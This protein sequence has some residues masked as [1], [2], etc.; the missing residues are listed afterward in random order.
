MHRF[1]TSSP[2]ATAPAPMVSARLRVCLLEVGG[3]GLVSTP[4]LPP[5]PAGGSAPPPLPTP[6]VASTR[7]V[8]DAWTHASS[9]VTSTGRGAPVG[10]APPL[11]PGTSHTPASDARWGRRCFPCFLA[12]PTTPT[13]WWHQPLYVSTEAISRSRRVWCRSREA[14]I[15]R[16]GPPNHGP[17]PRHSRYRAA[18][19]HPRSGGRSH[20]PGNSTPTLVP[21]SNPLS[22][23]Q[24]AQSPRA[25][26]QG[27]CT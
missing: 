7:Q 23:P 14:T 17:Q 4:V 1:V 3:G 27:C 24:R 5:H 25:P 26:L 21:R 20:R 9:R 22:C 11:A 18:L 13:P 8:S 12:T 19:V 16:V 10:E 2:R 15:R 6:L